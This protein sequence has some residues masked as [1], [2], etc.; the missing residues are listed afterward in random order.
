MQFGRTK[1]KNEL[2]NSL[3][4]ENK[5]DNY[6]KQFDSQVQKLK[7]SLAKYINMAK[8]GREQNDQHMMLTGIKYATYIEKNIGQ[9]RILKTN[10][11]VARIN[12]DN[13][14]AYNKFVMS[15]SDYTSELKDNKMSRWSI[16][17]IFR[18]YFKQTKNLAKQINL[19]DDRQEK[20][21]GK[22]EE[23]FIDSGKFEDVNVEDF[24][25]KHK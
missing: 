2:K 6:S 22:M 11:E 1:R 18:K 4:K 5:L 25:S 13:Q 21:D 12:L 8:E 19:I 7:Q 9:M 3:L 17:W 16:R 20:I 23:I 10:L 24:F 14:E 15:V